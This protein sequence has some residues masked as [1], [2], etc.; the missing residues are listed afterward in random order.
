MDYLKR[1]K[2]MISLRG[3]TDHTMKSYQTYI[4]AYLDYVENTLHKTPSQV[5]Y[6]DQRRF[7]E[8]LQKERNLSDRT[9]NVA[10]SQLRF[11]TLYVLHK[12]WVDTQLPMRKFDTY[13][14][15]VPTKEEAKIFISTMTD[16]KPK[17]MVAL[18][19]SSGLRIGEVCSLRYEDIQRKNMRI[20]ITHGKN[21][22][23]RMPSFPNRRLTFLPNTG[24]PA[25]DLL[26]AFFQNREILQNPLTPFISPDISQ[27]TRQNS[28]G[29][30][31]L[32]VILSGMLL[33]LIP[34]KMV[35]IL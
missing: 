20:H 15:F 30:N 27:N 17:A 22:S 19:Y 8:V 29:Q 12:P 2:K 33:E 13:L 18:M 11:F 31:A 5:S 7:L 6:K 34:T 25:E 1:Y 23:D 24:F 3:L 14:P 26:A 21:R 9:I 16:L 4:S 10:I 28:D 32:P 35:L